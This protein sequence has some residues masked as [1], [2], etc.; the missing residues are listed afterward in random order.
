V[1]A[2]ELHL[3]VIERTVQLRPILRYL[4][5]IDEKHKSANKRIYDEENKEEKERRRIETDKKASAV[6]LSVKANNSDQPPRKNIYSS[7]HRF[8]EDETWTKLGYYD[9]MSKE[10]NVIYE[11][12][13][14]TD[15]Q[16]LQ[17]K[18][19]ISAYFDMISA[20]SL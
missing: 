20:R 9:E 13:F 4:D 19:T 15:R 16:E 10:A 17:C 3:T 18:T 7:Q 11:R 14:A 6:Q 12:M 1:R 8:A 2:G 5:K